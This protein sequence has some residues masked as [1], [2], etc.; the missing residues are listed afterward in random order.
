MR[1]PLAA[2]FFIVLGFI[3]LAFWG[4]SS[5]LLSSVVD[6]MTPYANELGQSEYSNL[7]VELPV[8]FGIICVLFFIVGIV[9]FF[10]LD[11]MADEPELYWRR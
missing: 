5:F 10:I 1:F 3:F 6:A 9:L 8:A 7:L 11:A 2:V 4:F